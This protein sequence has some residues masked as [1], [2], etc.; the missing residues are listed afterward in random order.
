MTISIANL[1]AL[2]PKRREL[3]L[4][5][6]K[7][8]RSRRR[9][10]FSMYPDE[11]ALRRELYARHLEFFAL[12]AQYPT[13]CFMAANRV[14]KTEGGGG[15]EVVCHLTGRYPHWW[16][17]RRFDRHVDAWAAGDTK[18][19]VRDILQR[20]LLGAGTD[21]GTGL[22]PGDD[23]VRV[24]WRPN[25]GGA[26]DYVLVKHVSG[27]T[28]R[29]GFKSYD[30]GREAFQGTEKD[31]VWLD[32]ES[33]PGIRSECALRLMT[34]NGLLIETFTPLK[35]LTPIVLTYLEQ[36]RPPEGGE[37]TAVHGERALVMA[38]WDDVPHLSPQQKARML[39][40]CEPHLREARSRGVPSI[41]SGAIYP[42][43]EAE[44]VCEPFEIPAHW[45]RAYG[46]DVGWKR[47]AA[48]WGAHDRESGTTYLYSEH[49]Q[50]QAEPSVHAH[51]IRGR[52]AWIP[53]VIDPASRGRG[54]RDGL[55][56]IQDYV[57]LGLDLEPAQNAVEA[58]LHDVYQ[59]LA[60][61]RLKVFRTLSNWL[62]EYRIYRRDDRGHVVKEMDH[63]M[64]ATR[65][66]VVS[67][68]DR[69]K[70]SPTGRPESEED[71]FGAVGR[72]FVG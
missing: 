10:L 46:L 6:E 25:G 62:G 39:A 58:G 12:G 41:G 59:R 16:R 28:S 40:E 60:S 64:D 71:E 65:Y 32:E 67:G 24:V 44:I 56:L 19:T 3:A 49:Y 63:L 27:G 61:G 69:A 7:I 11:G 55:Q 52:G 29:L 43:A 23:I 70:V 34:R 36:G 33:S 72:V 20:K 42:V 50:G 1:N 14:G 54:Q 53:G 17:G 45:P 30:Q 35:G 15:Y 18:E 21:I 2:D 38:G 26:A 13:R 68:I 66:L 37:R 9:R 5:Q 4:L 48:V 22:I 57:D 47:T 8:R 51:A 31:V